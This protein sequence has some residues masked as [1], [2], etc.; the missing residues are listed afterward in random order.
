MRKTVF[1]AIKVND[2]ETSEAAQTESKE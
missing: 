2:P 1:S